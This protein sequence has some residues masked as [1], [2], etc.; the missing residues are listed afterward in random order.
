MPR[1]RVI[2]YFTLFVASGWSAEAAE[3]VAEPLELR[4]RSS[5][6]CQATVVRLSDLVEIHN[7]DAARAKSLAA[8]AITTAP[9]SGS[10]RELS[11]HEIRQIVAFSGVELDGITI[12]GSEVIVLQTDTAAP[13]QVRPVQRQP[14]SPGEIQQA[15]AELEIIPAAERQLRPQAYA[16][17]PKE[18]RLPQPAP[19]QLVERNA[20]VTIY[21]R[22]AGVRIRAAGKS[23]GHGAMGETIPVELEGSRER[24]LAKIVAPQT[25]EV[26]TAA[27][28][29]PAPP[30]LPVL[31]TAQR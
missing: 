24:I 10:S 26:T 14:L 25:V 18:P 8:I 31:P 7:E 16:E 11:R 15:A 6:V 5:I 12:T 17:R 30:R 22:A 29:P 28:V 21:S 4:L 23:L 19:P 2:L 1:C 3:T 20:A 9:A 13:P 27:A